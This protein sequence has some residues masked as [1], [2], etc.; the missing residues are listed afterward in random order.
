MPSRNTIMSHLS[1]KFL[2]MKN[3][4][5][6]ELSKYSEVCLTTDIWTHR[7]R[8]FIGV[9]CHCIDHEWKRKSFILAFRRMAKRHTYDNLAISL[10]QI[11]E[12]YSLD[13]KKITHIVTDGGSNF[14]KAFRVFGRNPVSE[15]SPLWSP[16]NEIEIHDE[17][18]VMIQIE[19]GEEED[20]AHSIQNVEEA[21][22]V[23]NASIESEQLD[24]AE[25]NSTPD[26]SLPPQMRCFAHLL[27]LIGNKLLEYSFIVEHSFSLSYSSIILQ[28]KWILSANSRSFRER[29]IAS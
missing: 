3:N 12:E 29:T 20:T 4:L 28:A 10:I 21:F 18:E 13:C 27:N 26:L 14:C 19:E 22:D 2:L 6:S 25:E 1:S 24:L 16:N 5:K 15:Y 7:S 17:E 23:E 8:S 11:I 9:S